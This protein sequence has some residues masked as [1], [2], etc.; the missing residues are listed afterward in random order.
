MRLPAVSSPTANFEI[1]SLAS[2]LAWLNTACDNMT[3]SPSS[4]RTASSMS[5]RSMRLPPLDATV[6]TVN[7]I[8]LHT[9]V[10]TAALPASREVSHYDAEASFES[11]RKAT[12]NLPTRAVLRHRRVHPHTTFDDLARLRQP[13][14]PPST[15]IRNRMLLRLLCSSGTTG[16]RKASCSPT[17]PWWRW[18]CSR[19]RQAESA[20]AG[21]RCRRICRSFMPLACSTTLTSAWQSGLTSVILPRFDFGQFLQLI[22]DYRVTRTFAAPP[23]LVQL[24]KNPIV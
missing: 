20:R 21:C 18:R 9:E 22:Q 13:G 5:S 11:S 16:R 4:R 12:E 17:A 24:A 6:S 15:S 7:P 14:P 2:P 3:S 8:Y 10:R 23:I 1:R 19:Q